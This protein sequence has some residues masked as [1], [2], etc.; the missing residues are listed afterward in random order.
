MNCVLDASAAFEVSFNGKDAEKIRKILY[1]ADVTYAPH[2]YIAEVT[3]VLWKYI[4]AGF[5]TEQNAQIT[6]ALMLQYVDI[7]T[8]CT[9][10]TVEAMHEGIRLNHPVYDMYYFTLARRNAALLLTKDKKLQV[11]AKKEGVEVWE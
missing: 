3:N 6:L 9:D 11:L 1:V 4:K 5:I 10:N 7:F 2:L 8:D